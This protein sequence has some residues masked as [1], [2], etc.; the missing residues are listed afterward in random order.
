MKRFAIPAL[1][2]ATTFLALSGSAL[3]Y[4][5]SQSAQ[6]MSGYAQLSHTIDSKSAI[7][8]QIVSAKLTGSIQTTE[9]LKLPSGTELLGHVDRAQASKNNGEATIELTFDKA[10][11]KDGQQVPIKANLL[12]VISA[13]SAGEIPTAVANDD[14]F[15][16]ETTVSGE[17]LHSAVQNQNSGTIVR[18]DKDVHLVGGTKLLIAVAPASA[19]A[20]TISGS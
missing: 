14:K 13:D 7:P 11:L 18:K 10:Q 9:G 15:D 19:L 3:V 20:G 17:S 1:S 5:Q 8:G 6:L 16:Q 2:I 4:G 12:E